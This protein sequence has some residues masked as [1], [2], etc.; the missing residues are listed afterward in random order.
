MQSVARS[1][2]A[3][4][5]GETQNRWADP[6]HAAAKAQLRLRFSEPGCN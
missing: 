4:N 3:A 1:S 2:L 5:S 6:D